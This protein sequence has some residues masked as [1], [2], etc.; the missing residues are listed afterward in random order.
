MRATPCWPLNSTLSPLEMGL[1]PL[2][3]NQETV[4]QIS[5][6]KLQR[7]AISTNKDLEGYP[8]AVCKSEIR[9]LKAD[10]S[11]RNSTVQALDTWTQVQ[12]WQDCQQQL[13]E[14][15]TQQLCI[16][17]DM[18]DNAKR[19]KWLPVYRVSSLP[20][21]AYLTLY[22]INSWCLIGNW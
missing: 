14:Q 7:S 17:F 2:P 10:I 22:W 18:A 9:S 6:L 11:H 16:L 13:L 8:D 20:F 12:Q 4:M 21:R 3:R 1:N 15:H 19:S 5:A